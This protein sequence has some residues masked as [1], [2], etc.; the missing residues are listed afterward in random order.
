MG[1]E[2]LS[3]LSKLESRAAWKRS[4]IKSSWGPSS[5]CRPSLTAQ[6]E[7]CSLLTQGGREALLKETI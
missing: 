3:A 5:S 2:G 6:V 4:P 7:I 1:S